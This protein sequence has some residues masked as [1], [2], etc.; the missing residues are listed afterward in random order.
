MWPLQNEWQVQE[1]QRDL[2]ARA[3]QQH[4]IALA[5]AGEPRRLAYFAPLLIWLG[6]CLSTWGAQL[7]TRYQPTSAGCRASNV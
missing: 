6:R 1:R 7:E 3:E 2:L 4:R 5:V